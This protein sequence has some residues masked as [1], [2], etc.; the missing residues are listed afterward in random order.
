M[1]QRDAFEAPDADV[2][3]AV[4]QP[5]QVQVVRQELLRLGCPPGAVRVED[6]ADERWS[7]R[8]EQVEETD[9]PLVAPT[10]AGVVIPKEAAK[11]VSIAIPTGAAIGALLGLPFAVIEAGSLGLGMRL[12]WCAVVGAALGS[13]VA[14]L[15]GTAMSAKDPYEPSAAQ[16]GVVVR[17]DQV[18]PAVEAALVRLAP[19]RIDRFDADGVV[20]GTIT[21]EEDRQPGGIVEE[22]AANVRRE[23]EADPTD[24]HR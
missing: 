5:H 19:I 15:V 13:T 8:A 21:T 12:L 20:L 17:V 16:R 14:Y 23:A 9:Q 22:V 7:L 6:D 2:L 24:R 10:H 4:F 1:A 11:A 3:V 18:T